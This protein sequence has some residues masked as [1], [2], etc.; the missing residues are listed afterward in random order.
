MQCSKCHSLAC[1][2]NDLDKAPK[3]CPTV[4]DSAVFQEAH[5]VY[6]DPKTRKISQTAAHVEV[7]GY[8]QWPRVQEL[9]IF[10]K[11][12]GYKK[13]GIAFCIGLKE[14]AKILT[15][16][17]EKNGFEVLNGICTIGSLQKKELDIPDEDTF[18][19]AEEVGC[20]PIGQAYYFNSKKTDLNIVVGLC[21]GHDIN[22]IKNSKAPT[23]VL[24]V[25]DRVTTHNP[26]AVLYSRYY[27]RKFLGDTK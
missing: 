17:L 9:I 21:I 4:D 8:M 24:I 27:K 13:L 1:K 7:T 2:E 25:K 12:M 6:D 20:N 19:T 22:F 3:G 11:K 15:Q 23:T 10:S 5:K 18:T 14:E 26:A 16:I